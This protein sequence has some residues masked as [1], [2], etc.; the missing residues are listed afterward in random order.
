[1]FKNTISFLKN[2]N[3]R[4]LNVSLRN[5][6][7]NI[8]A[9]NAKS[10]A[11]PT[12]MMSSYM[13]LKYNNRNY[14][15][16]HAQE[17]YRQL[18]LTDANELDDGQMKEVKYGT[19]EN[20][21]IL[22]VKYK[23]KLYAMSNYCPHFGAPLH[24]GILVDNLLKCPWHGASFDITTGQ[25]EVS[26]S[27]NDLPLYEIFE[28]EKGYYVNIP[29][30]LQNV[31]K[32]KVP[33][34]SKRDP[35]DKRKFLIIGGGP[36][37]LSASESLRQSGY[38]GEIIMLSKDEYVPYDRTILSKFIPKDMSKIQLRSPEFLKEYDID[39]KNKAN[40]V[41]L[42]NKNKKVILEDGSEYTYDKLLLATGAT[43]AKPKITGIDKKH[44]FT[45]RT[46]DDIQNISEMGSK[47][48]DI[49]LIGG[50][51]IGMESASN[52]KKAFKTAN[53]TIIEMNQT[54]F[55][56]SLGKEVG[57]ALQK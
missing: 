44:V 55:Y 38:T 30:D 16:L 25:K 18:F 12:I 14:S 9:I 6:K 46:Y 40:V 31:K 21:S 36:A 4:Y 29:I 2:L 27:L 41:T 22:V 35:N 47:S 45:L 37:A 43:P 34:M 5:G 32:S 23:G 8:Q 49:V 11:I 20:E 19:K 57:S 3:K 42:D 26:P 17:E 52:L 56:A 10:L 7:R 50:N 1:M 48:K 54:P 13:F 53:V 39:I 15:N 51:F 28:N 24:T 33:P